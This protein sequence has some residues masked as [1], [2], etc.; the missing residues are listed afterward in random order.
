MESQHTSQYTGSSNGS[1]SKLSSDVSVY[2]QPQGS[3]PKRVNLGVNGEQEMVSVA[4]SNVI[5]AE[6]T[7]NDDVR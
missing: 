1:D 5:Q 7:E 3:G 4:P 2:R 6:E